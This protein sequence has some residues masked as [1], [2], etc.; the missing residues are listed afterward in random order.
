MPGILDPNPLNDME[1]S[2]WTTSGFPGEPKQQSHENA[3]SQDDLLPESSFTHTINLPP[4]PIFLTYND[5]AQVRQRSACLG[6]FDQS[7]FTALQP[8]NSYPAIAPNVMGVSEKSSLKRS[9][10]EE[11]SSEASQQRKKTSLDLAISELGEEDQLLMRLKEKEN[12]PWKDIAARFY[13][14]LGKSYQI[15][16]LQMRFKRLR[17]RIHPWTDVDINALRRAHDHWEKQKWEIISAKM[18]DFGALERW[19]A[20]SCGR[21]LQEIVHDYKRITPNPTADLREDFAGGYMPP[22][23]LDG[24][25]KSI[26]NEPA[27]P[28]D[29]SFDASQPCRENS[30][31]L[32]LQ[33]TGCDR[34]EEFILPGQD[35]GPGASEGRST[36]HSPS[37]G[38]K[39]VSS[40]K[41]NFASS[42]NASA[43]GELQITVAGHPNQFK[44]ERGIKK[45]RSV[46][47]RD[48]IRQNE[49]R[50]P[51]PPSTIGG[52]AESLPSKEPGLRSS[53]V[54]HEPQSPIGS[55]SDGLMISDRSLVT[56]DANTDS[57]Y[58]SS[59]MSQ[60]QPR[61]GS[62]F[63]QTYQAM[64]RRASETSEASLG[65]QELIND[66]ANNLFTDI[67][68]ELSDFGSFR[69]ACIRLPHLL[70]G[71]ALQL[72]VDPP[73][74]SQCTAESVRTFILSHVG[75]IAGA[76][77]KIWAF[78][79]NCERQTGNSNTISSRNR[80]HDWLQDHEALGENADAYEGTRVGG[81]STQQPVVPE[82]KL[83]FRAVLLSDPIVYQW[84][85]KNLRKEI[86]MV[87]ADPDLV[88]NLRDRILNF[89][90]APSTSNNGSTLSASLE[91]LEFCLD[92]DPFTFIRE[93]NYPGPPHKAIGTAI[94]LTGS[95]D[96]AQALTCEQYMQQM[97]PSSGQYVLSL[98]K[99]IIQR[100]GALS[101]QILPNGTSLTGSYAQS[102]LT[103]MVRGDMHS[104]AEVGEQLAWLGAALR[105]SP[106][107]SG[108]T[109]CTPSASNFQPRKHSRL[110]EPFPGCVLEKVSISAGKIVVGSGTIS[111]GCRDIP[112]HVSRTELI[113]KLQWLHAKY[114]VLWDE[115]DERGWLVNGTSALLHL[116]RASLEYNKNDSFQSAF[117][118]H[119]EDWEE[120]PVTH[121]TDSAVR[122]L[123]N[124]SNLELKIYPERPEVWEEC[125]R[126]GDGEWETVSKRKESYYCVGDRVDE[127]YSILEKTV[128]HQAGMN[129][130][131][132]L[133]I[134]TPHNEALSWSRKV[135]AGYETPS[136]DSGLGSSI[137]SSEANMEESSEP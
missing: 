135:P 45:V 28:A 30:E 123:L 66:I 32:D 127:L 80:I 114:M 50:R 131:A 100:E 39:K 112:I 29:D 25:K 101:G 69:R 105:P 75:L 54:T 93:Q 133:E 67:R 17:E 96:D 125:T 8:R 117:L 6:N 94:T 85:L 15:P 10:T 102:L 115:A 31:H 91:V 40:L 120:A 56:N 22:F 49:T 65:K 36:L 126:R 60:S 108:V 59:L 106:S 109:L 23:L 130:P 73:S 41:Q 3:N 78:E 5:Q 124:R 11:A 20:M 116:L 48:Y 1:C 38:K 71:F 35:F 82:E 47:M 12:L 13:S 53:E 88:G 98:V 103:V 68:S 16:A 27:F 24:Q 4:E 21:K 2:H 137:Q 70:R 107:L 19:P 122:V 92:W 90:S 46:A 136:T 110:P 113:P 111:R 84:L 37:L 14:D 86:R 129:G 76:F 74:S 9:R 62:A 97:W 95:A 63:E 121:A 87:P 57:G 52:P 44:N 119:S 118:Y 26:S 34:S 42:A 83:D 79:E 7:E 64:G 81:L 58:G 33:I 55:P 18:V 77:E 61:F 89:I 99:D 43:P 132:A 72:R 128:E 134:Q 51:T 104:I